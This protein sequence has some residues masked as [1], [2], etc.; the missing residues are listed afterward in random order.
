MQVFNL[1]MLLS[2][3]WVITLSLNSLPL[4]VEVIIEMGMPAALTISRLLFYLSIQVA[5]LGSEDSNDQHADHHNND[6]Y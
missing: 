2:L 4:R 5:H 6:K 1:E 3:N